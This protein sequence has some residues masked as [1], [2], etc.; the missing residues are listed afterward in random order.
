MVAF[1][2]QLGYVVYV[3]ASSANTPRVLL[4]G[5]VA[6]KTQWPF[7]AIALD[8]A[9]EQTNALVKGDG[10]VVDLTENA[11]ALLQWMVAGPELCRMVE[12]FETDTNRKESTKHH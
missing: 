2:P 11:S 3:R 7:S 12:E 8:H 4:G 5:F 9:H 1:S 6:C 10:G